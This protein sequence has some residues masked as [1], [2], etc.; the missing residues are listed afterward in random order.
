[1]GLPLQ[2]AGSEPARALPF[3][4]LVNTYLRGF[5]VSP[6]LRPAAQANLL[7]AAAPSQSKDRVKVG[8]VLHKDRMNDAVRNRI[9]AAVGV[10]PSQVQ[11]GRGKV[12]VNVEER[13]LNALAADEVR[14]IENYY[15]PKLSNNIARGLI[16]AD[17]AQGARR[18]AA[19]TRSSASPT[20]FDKGDTRDVHAAF[21]GRVVKLYAL[22]RD[23]AADDP[24]GHGTHVGGSVLGDLTAHDGNVIRGTAPAARLVNAVGTGLVW[25]PRRAATR[26]ARPL[27]A[28]VSRRRRPGAH[29][30]LGQR[31]GRHLHRQ[32][33]RGRRFRQH[34][35]R[36]GDLL[37]RR[38]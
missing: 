36:L 25:R 26:P 2:A 17:Q 7:A 9:A 15:P 37:R 32:R 21:E 5:K 14:H 38:Q 28:A 6:R 33:Q 18:C 12:R 31:R 30:F 11:A 34:P 4:A 3:V 13:R 10:D 8:V 29:Q 27:S 24:D 35:P 16:N 1:M 20:G 19:R 23:N 22:G